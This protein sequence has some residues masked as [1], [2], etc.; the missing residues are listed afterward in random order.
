MKLSDIPSLLLVNGGKELRASALK[1]HNYA[2]VNGLGTGDMGAKVEA[3]WKD[4][5]GLLKVD[6]GL[7]S[8][9]LFLGLGVPDIRMDCYKALS[10]VRMAVKRGDT[11]A[12]KSW[13]QFCDFLAT[14]AAK[15]GGGGKPPEEVKITV[16]KSAVNLAPTGNSAATKAMEVLNAQNG[17]RVNF[18]EATVPYTVTPAGTKV[19]IDTTGIPEGVV[20]AG[21]SE[22]TV[23]F[24]NPQ[25]VGTGVVKLKAG[26]A[27]AVINV[28]VLERGLTTESVPDVTVGETAT[29]PDPFIK[30]YQTGAHVAKVMVKKADE[31]VLTVSADGKQ[32][33]G[34][35]DG[36]VQLYGVITFDDSKDISWADSSGVNV[37]DPA[38]EHTTRNNVIVK[39]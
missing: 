28:Q 26:N 15:T 2:V 24:S 23:V 18:F 17:T 12:G 6:T 39:E 7:P 35:S 38:V 25:K 34:V 19:T 9:G 33:T 30:P 13:E 10:Y 8:D 31:A 5:M 20:S 22:G 36:R 14:E 4:Q 27:E 3:F 16:G 1:L 11:D 29:M 21:E 32:V 37:N